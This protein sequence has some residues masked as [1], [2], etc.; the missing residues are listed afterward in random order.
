MQTS[1]EDI[2]IVIKYEDGRNLGKYTNSFL[3]KVIYRLFTS[4]TD[5]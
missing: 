5:A 2:L 4:L 3:P 1:I